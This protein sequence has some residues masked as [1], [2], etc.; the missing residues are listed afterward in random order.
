[1]QVINYVNYYGRARTR[2]LDIGEMRGRLIDILNNFRASHIDPIDFD[3][4]DLETEFKLAAWSWKRQ[5][6]EI[7]L[8]YYDSFSRAYTFRPSTS[9]RGQGTSELGCGKRIAIAGDYNDVFR[10]KLIDRLRH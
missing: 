5:D 2:E 4:N 9:W 6:F 3:K 8:F 10:K 1:M 7:S